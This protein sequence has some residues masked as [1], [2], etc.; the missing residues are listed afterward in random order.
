MVFKFTLRVMVS[1]GKLFEDV[2]GID[3]ISDTIHVWHGIF[4]NISTFTNK[5]STKCR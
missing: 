4:T 5:I 3:L 1:I 2:M